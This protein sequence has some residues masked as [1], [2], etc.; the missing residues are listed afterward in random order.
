MSSSFN[1]STSTSIRTVVDSH[2][3]PR[4]LTSIVASSLNWL[5]DDQKEDV[6]TQA[7]LRLSE[8]SGRN[9][10][11]AMTRKFRVNDSLIIS[12]HE[13]SLTEDNLGLK[14]WTSSLL[15]A[16]RLASFTDYVRPKCR[17]LEL[18]SGTG[19][20]G[21]A[22]ASV[23]R[24]LLQEITLTDLPE[25]V[26]NL[27]RNIEQN[28][29][30]DGCPHIRSRALDWANEL[31]HPADETEY[32]DLIIAADP[33][34][35]SEHAQLLADTVH[36]WL[37]YRPSATFVLELPLRDAYVKERDDLRRRLSAFLTIK[38]EGE[39]TGYDDWLDSSG[40]PAE[41]RCSWTVWQRGQPT[42]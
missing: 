35:S 11:P 5:D 31:D 26:P 33:I 7:S 39:E 32:F 42:T 22:A 17:L 24:E 4:Y 14:T 27:Q 34:Y 21:I 15:L 18:G 9:A 2:G 6:W 16:R 1:P 19:L 25:I 30:S 38:E 10:A 23:W 28:S 13:P 37:A 20:V 40:Q 12:L 29:S 3:I 41:V 36:R 8:R